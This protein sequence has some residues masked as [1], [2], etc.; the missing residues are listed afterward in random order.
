MLADASTE[1]PLCL[2]ESGVHTMEAFSDFIWNRMER[3]PPTEAEMK[4][5]GDW[6]I[7]ADHT[8]GLPRIIWQNC[9]ED[10]L[11]MVL[12]MSGLHYCHIPEKIMDA[13]P[14]AM[15]EYILEH[16]NNPEDL[17]RKFLDVSETEFRGTGLDAYD[18]PSPA[19]GGGAEIIDSEATPMQLMTATLPKGVEIE[20]TQGRCVR[21]SQVDYRN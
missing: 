10:T 12:H 13:V 14:V 2:T 15:N 8:E 17:A 18:A 20:A 19:E 4:T 3:P 7:S 5:V 9:D 6:L 11:D 1:K 16:H 21:A